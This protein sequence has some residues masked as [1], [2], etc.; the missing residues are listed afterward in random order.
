MSGL[1]VFALIVLLVLLVVVIAALV[2]LGM[3]PGKIATQRNHPQAEAINVAGWLGV[4]SLGILYPLGLIWAFTKPQP[5]RGADAS[6]ED[7]VR[8]LDERV[9]ALEKALAKRA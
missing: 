9:E 4:L 8:Q 1:D 5:D 3:L 6:D 7:T 2:G